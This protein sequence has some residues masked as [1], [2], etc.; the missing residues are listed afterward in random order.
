MKDVSTTKIPKDKLNKITKVMQGI[1]RGRLFK[2]FTINM[3]MLAY[4]L[5][6]IAKVF[7]N[8][9]T[10]MKI[11]I[12]RKDLKPLHSCVNLDNL[13]AKYGGKL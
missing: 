6:K 3:P 12:Q 1:E 7:V 9:Y 4:A 2:L 10:L 8:K 11:D 5:W 13:E